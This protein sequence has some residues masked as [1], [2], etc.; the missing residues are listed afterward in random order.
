MKI[1]IEKENTLQVE[2]NTKLILLNVEEFVSAIKRGSSFVPAGHIRVSLKYKLVCN[3]NE[4]AG[5]SIFDSYKDISN[6]IDANSPYKVQLVNWKLS[7]KDEKYLEFNFIN[8]N[9]KN[10][11]QNDL[12]ELRKTINEKMNL[13]KNK[14]DGINL[15]E[16]EKEKYGI[17]IGNCRW[18]LRNISLKYYTLTSKYKEMISIEEYNDCLKKQNII[19]NDQDKWVDLESMKVTYEKLIIVDMAKKL[20]KNANHS[21]IEKMVNKIDDK[22][23]ELEQDKLQSNPTHI[24][25][26]KLEEKLN[27]NKNEILNN[28]KRIEN[29]NATYYWNSSRGGISLIVSDDGS[30]LAATSSVNYDRHLEEFKN[31]KRNGDFK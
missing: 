14:L 13:L 24:Y 29:E 17:L 25:M 4:Y 21:E 28:S 20:T 5:E 30:Y 22:I 10:N 18:L 2:E 3:N 27:M 15:D 31:G 6:T 12:K 1:Y 9:N 16:T 26:S 11:S 7:D 19:N 23:F 8:V